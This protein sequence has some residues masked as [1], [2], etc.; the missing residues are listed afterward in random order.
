MRLKKWREE[1][2][3]QMLTPNP[4]YD[5][6]RATEVRKRAKKSKKSK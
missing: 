3:A 5:S 2:G 6:K 4:Q 1:V